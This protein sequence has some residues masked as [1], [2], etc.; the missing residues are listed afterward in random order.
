MGRD[1]ALHE[2]VRAQHH[3]GAPDG[4]A[5]E[6]DPDEKSLPIEEQL[7]IGGYSGRSPAP[8][9]EFESSDVGRRVEG[10]RS[11]TEFL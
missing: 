3:N 1:G 6:V 4:A 2:L 5:P 7:P 11:R 10:Q 9:S 8:E